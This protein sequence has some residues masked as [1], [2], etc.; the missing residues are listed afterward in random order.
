MKKSLT[1]QGLIKNNGVNVQLGRE[2][3][4]LVTDKLE[5]RYGVDLKFIYSNSERVRFD[6]GT[7]RDTENFRTTYQMDS[8]SF[9]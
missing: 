9:S 3:R 4:S 6:T 1:H 2:W 7:L 5:L 8:M